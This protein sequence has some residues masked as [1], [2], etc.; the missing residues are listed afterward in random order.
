[1]EQIIKLLPPLKDMDFPLMKAIEMRRT[2]RKWKN[3]L[4]SLQEISDLCWVACGETKSATKR[5]KNRRTVPSGCNSQLITLHVA[6]DS[7]VYKY[8]EPMHN[9]ELITDSD[10]RPI[11]GTQKMMQSAPLGLIY[12]A[13]FSKRTGIIKSNP[14]DKMFVA[15]TEAGLMSQNVYLYSSATGLNTV[16]IAL[17]NRDKLRE[18]MGLHED[19]IVIYTQVVGK[20]L[21]SE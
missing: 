8:F 11:I 10:I 2:K 17:V 9:L 16:L 15:G 14:N 1:M 6:L 4:L 13:D 19:E 5:S 21:E 18:V 3:E 12:V 7:G 20:S